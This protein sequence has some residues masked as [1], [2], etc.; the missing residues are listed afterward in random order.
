MLCLTLL[1]GDYILIG[2]AVILQYYRTEGEKCR[3]SVR[4]PKDIPI[5]RG[6]VLERNGMERPDCIIDKKPHWHKRELMWNRSKAQAL[7]AMRLLLSKMD[8]ND[9]N[10]RTL[11]RQL[12]H[13]F[14]ESEKQ[15]G[16]GTGTET[17]NALSRK[18]TNGNAIKA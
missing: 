17:D 15:T 6:K 2:E 11:R 8:S 4:A 14:P 10:V 1:P 13:M 3:L 7:T 12:N 9:A 16:C 5:V 18:Q